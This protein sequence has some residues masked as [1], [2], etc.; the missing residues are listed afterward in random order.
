MLS[1]CG[2]LGMP[3]DE[4]WRTTQKDEFLKILEEDKYASICDEQALYAKVKES[5]SSKLMSQLL[6]AYTNNLANGCID[7]EDFD[8]SQKERQDNNISTHYETYLQEVQEEYVLLRVKAGLTIEE[9]LK[10]YVPTYQQF[11]MLKTKYDL[12]RQ[13]GSIPKKTLRKMRLNLERIKLFKPDLGENYVL[14][15]VPEYV[16][17]VIENNQTSISMRVIVGQ[18]KMQTPIFAADIQSIAMNPQW[19]VPDSIARNEVIPKLIEDP[20]YLVSQNMVVRRSYDLNTTDINASTIDWTAYLEEEKGN[21][22]MTYKFIE[23]PSVR[24]GLGRVKFLFPNKHHVY[25]HDTQTKKLFKRKV[26]TFSHGCVRL[27]KPNM[28]LD[29]LSKNY[30]EK[31]DEEM[32][33]LYD[34]LQTHYVSLDKKLPVHTAYLTTYVNENGEVLV[35]DDIYGFDRLQK[36]NF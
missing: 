4:G 3:D 6:V 25:M 29:H 10:P 16:V 28:M 1:G 35:I 5:E 33:T 2:V 26:R 19:N 24:N 34:S 18:R 32:K 31:T 27:Q 20:N 8:I 22:N 36:L 11:A 21:H 13:Q 17:R 15:N 7:I 12:F 14:V 30:T 23:V 9:I